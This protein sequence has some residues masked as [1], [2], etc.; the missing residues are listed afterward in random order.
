MGMGRRS[1]VGD[2]WMLRDGRAGGV[3]A[4]RKRALGSHPAPGPPSLTTSSET[5]DNAPLPMITDT[6]DQLTTVERQ[7]GE[8]SRRGQAF[9]R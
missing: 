6:V 5:G 8:R 1:A 9:A 2:P 7:R 4:E 3:A